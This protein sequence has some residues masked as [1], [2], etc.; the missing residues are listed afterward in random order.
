M[1]IVHQCIVHQCIP[2]GRDL[3]ELPLEPKGVHVDGHASLGAAQHAE[4]GVV[5]LRDE[6]Q[7][8]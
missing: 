7:F 3:D 8:L 5:D 6:K 4:G 1:H 2:V